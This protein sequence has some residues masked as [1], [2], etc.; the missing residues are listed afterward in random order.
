M[1]TNYH[2]HTYRCKHAEGNDEEYVKAA[3]KIGLKE[4]GFTDHSPWPLHSIEKGIIRMDMDLLPAYVDSIRLLQKKY[5]GQIK[6]Y[7]GLEAEYFEDRIEWLKELVNKYQFD[8]LIFGNHFY[9]YETF[10]RYF[11][12][13]EN[14]GSILED[15]LKTS[16]KGM[17]TKLYRIF[18]HPDLFMK[19]YQVWDSHCERI[20]REICKVAIEEGIYLE[21]NLGGV[22]G[23]SIN[24]LGYPDLNFWKI[25]AEEKCPSVIG[26]DAHSPNHFYEEKMFND[27]EEMLLD[28]GVNLKR[29]IQIK[30]R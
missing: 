28:L 16:I 5:E 27:T 14:R 10:E 25:V 30:E 19:T 6:I 18:A 21:Y 11:G 24:Q 22:R 1:I 3:I 4:I 8:Y 20:T 26:I 2:T 23:K 12:H 15:Y 7:L 13:Y 29:K 17:R 9:Q